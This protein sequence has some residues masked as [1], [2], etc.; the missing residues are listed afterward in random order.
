MRMREGGDIDYQELARF[1]RER[2]FDEFALISESDIQAPVGRRPR[3]LLPGCRAVIIFG[4][5]MGDDVF[6]S[7]RRTASEGVRR[8]K[9]ELRTAG[10]ELVASLTGEGYAARTAGAVVLRD[11]TIRGSLSL[12]HCAVD[13][14]LGE[15]GDSTL[16]ISPRFGNRLALGAVITSKEVRGTTR[17]ERPCGICTHCGRCITACPENA[18]QTGKIDLFRCRNVTGTIPGSLRA[19]VIRL[20][21]AG[22]KIPLLEPA[23]NLVAGR[24]VPRCSECLLACPHYRRSDKK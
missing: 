20:I 13:A 17:P 14:G 12:K 5:V 24:S 11:G 4:K 6:S 19:V 15:I 2:S 21:N 1:F 10:E 3:D 16:L 23:I 7:E 22:D 9:D 8:L 18:L